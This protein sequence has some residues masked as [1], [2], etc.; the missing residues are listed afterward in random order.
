MTNARAGLL[1][2]VA[3]ALL[4]A[5]LV[6]GVALLLHAASP[7]PSPHVPARWHAP[8]ASPSADQS[9]VRMQREEIPAW[10]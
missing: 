5:L 8:A 6:L 10:R 2:L 9:V 3:L 7:S 1:G 4:S